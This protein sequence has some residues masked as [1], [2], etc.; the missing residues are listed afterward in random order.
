MRVL[1]PIYIYPSSSNWNPIFTQLSNYPKL[2]FTVII[3]PSSGP[4]SATPSSAYQTYV[5]QLKNNTNALVLGYVNA[6]YG[7]ANLTNIQ[8]DIDLYAQWGRSYAPQG[9]Y[10]DQAQ[11]TGTI[12]QNATTYAKNTYPTTVG[13]Y[14]MVVT[15]QQ[16]TPSAYYTTAN[17]V[18]Q[19]VDSYQSYLNPNNTPVVNYA[20]SGVMMYNF[21]G[22]TQLLQNTT[23]NL[24][25]S[26]LNSLLI[27]NS[28]D[29]SWSSFGSDW[30]TFCQIMNSTSPIYSSSSSGVTTAT[31]EPPDAE[32][33]N[34][35]NQAL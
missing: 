20:N 3:N 14:V 16:N 7:S 1:L 24:A 31:V 18:V 30:A 33:Y 9:I 17:L 27:T 23:Q 11:L 12:I 8:S 22:S 32:C 19:F 5:A 4:G 15:D 2:N 28:A 25:N 29:G 13:S 10:L 21:T 34:F 6:G 26:N 35:T